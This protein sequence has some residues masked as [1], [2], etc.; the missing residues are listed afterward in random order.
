M[1]IIR[2]V[3]SLR[4]WRG[5]QDSQIGKVGF[6]PTMGALHAGH[7]SL[8][9]RARRSCRTVVVSIFVNPLQ[10]G[11]KEDLK[12]YPRSVKADI[13]LCQRAGVDVMWIP[14]Q[15]DLYPTAF[16]T[17]VTLNQLTKRWEGE[18][19]PTH[20]QGVATV[21][22]KLFIVV[23]PNMAFFGQKDYQQYLVVKQLVKD[24]N[25]NVKIMLCPTVREPD[26]LAL[27][28][29]NHHLPPECR[30][31]APVLY[32]A[33]CAGKETIQEGRRSSERIVNAM[34]KIVHEESKVQT[35]YFVVC[36]PYTLEPLRKVKD[37]AVLLGAI[38]VGGIR[39]IDN[40]LVK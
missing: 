23:R 38:R 34:S 13:A 25:L 35:D 29:R 7:L 36:D 1:Q 28:S 12:R 19:R 10:F 2:S 31:I 22:T 11:P 26:G 39:L 15:K 16:Q 4:G 3:L 5:R 21:L 18:Y 37:G 33:L 9:Q 17:A 30:R 14:S 6:V 8:I 32:K 27:S 40:L 20:F 24:L